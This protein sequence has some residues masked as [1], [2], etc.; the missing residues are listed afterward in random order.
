M[1]D[2]LPPIHKQLLGRLANHLARIVRRQRFNGS[3]GAASPLLYVPCCFPRLVPCRRRPRSRPP[4][5]VSGYL[6]V[7]NAGAGGPGRRAR[8]R[9]RRG[10]RDS[11]RRRRQAAH[12][13][14]RLRAHAGQP[15]LAEDGGEKE[16]AGCHA[17][18]GPP[19]ARLG[20]PPPPPMAEGGG[21]GRPAPGLEPP[22]P[23]KAEGPIAPA[24][25]ARRTSTRSTATTVTTMESPCGTLW[26]RF[27]GDEGAR[28]GQA[29]VALFA[30][31]RTRAAA[32]TTRPG[33]WRLSKSVVGVGEQI[34]H[35]QAH[36][37][38][39]TTCRHGSQL[40]YS[41]F[42]DVCVILWEM[43]AT[44]PAASDSSS[45]RNGSRWAATSS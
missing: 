43:T 21:A 41:H 37:S 32:R 8:P 36:R 2:D 44:R 12:R 25:S 6:R 22:P 5:L 19:P 33:A 34:P 29:G 28:Q 17:P 35:N 38:S 42:G 14:R 30:R 26:T 20:P 4:S 24:P 1:V 23:P 3:T 31:R 10:R 11:R 45:A 15:L 18:A 27:P 16:V 9:A 40:S 7:V 39:R 13:V